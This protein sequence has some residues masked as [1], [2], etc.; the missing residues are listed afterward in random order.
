MDQILVYV[1]AANDEEARLLAET[2]VNEGLAACANIVPGITSIFRWQGKV[3][4]ST[5]TLCLFKST[6][7]HFA[8]LNRRVLELHS[9][10]TP[11]VVALPL[12]DGNPAFMKW[13]LDSMPKAK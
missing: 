9:Y 3:E 11:C 7:G 10:E 4:T 12:V 5:E 1:T 6:S 13:I 2:L 8:A